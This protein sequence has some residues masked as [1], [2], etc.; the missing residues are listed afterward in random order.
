MSVVYPP[1]LRIFSTVSSFSK[2][3][4]ILAFTS[5]QPGNKNDIS[6]KHTT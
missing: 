5:Q 6:A 2:K 4:L 1:V 3:I